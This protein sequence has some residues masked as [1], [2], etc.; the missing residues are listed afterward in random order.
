VAAVAAKVL[1]TN[2]DPWAGCGDHLGCQW[3]DFRDNPPK[4]WLILAEILD[5]NGD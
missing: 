2:V 5:R 3:M 1:P 4:K